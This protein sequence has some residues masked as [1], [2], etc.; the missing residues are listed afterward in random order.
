[1]FASIPNWAAALCKTLHRLV[2]SSLPSSCIVDRILGAVWCRPG[3]L[4]VLGIHDIRIW[5]MYV[6]LSSHTAGGA[7]RIRAAVRVVIG[8]VLAFVITYLVGLLTG[9]QG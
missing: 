2:T 8:G 9:E 7:K 6:R 5:R 3:I 1:M 4:G